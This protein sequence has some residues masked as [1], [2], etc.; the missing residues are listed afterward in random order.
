MKSSLFS[1]QKKKILL[2][3][4]EEELVSS[5][6]EV[7][8]EN[9]YKVIIATNGMEAIKKAKEERPDLILLDIMMPKMDGYE[10]LRQLKTSAEAWAI[11]V[12][13]V[14]ARSDSGSI[15]KTQDSRAA[16]YIIKPFDVSEVL[17][18]IQRY[19]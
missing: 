13:M 9:G 10:V 11:S 8:E 3:D 2:I 19:I 5:L 7:L 4:D 12:I 15:L 18:S 1:K 16:D 6:S 17:S 14:T